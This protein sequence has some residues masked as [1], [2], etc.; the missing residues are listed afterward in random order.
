V[1][2]ALKNLTG[3]DIQTVLDNLL[4]RALEPIVLNTSIFDT[5]I[6][7]I[8][9]RITVNKKRKLVSVDRSKAISLLAKALTETKCSVKFSLIVQSK[10]ER[11]II[12][13]FINIVLV[14]LNHFDALY[15]QNLTK[16]DLKIEERMLVIAS[17]LGVRD[18]EKLFCVKAQV[19]EFI[20]AYFTYRNSIVD[21]YVKFTHKVS[22]SFRTSKLNNY[23]KGDVLQNFLSAVTKAI[24]KY[25]SSKGALTSYINYWL[26]NAQT[27]NSNSSEYGI[28]YTLP[29]GKKR[30]KVDDKSCVNFSMSLDSDELLNMAHYD[31]AHENLERMEENSIIQYLT[32]MVD[33]KGCIRLTMDID[34]YYTK[35]EYA[36]MCSHMHKCKV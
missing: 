13:R 23:D 28:A 2:P 32:K 35:K 27:C 12:H 7:H 31:N 18:Y 15:K 11:C 33:R 20:G 16:R 26:L 30:G 21:H 19:T 14:D 24:D 22:N 1:N 4:Y 36:L 9:S 3:G 17:S 34:E 10:I 29:H 25:D 6:V 5:Q 8:L